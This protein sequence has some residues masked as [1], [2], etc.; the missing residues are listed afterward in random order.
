MLKSRDL[1]NLLNRAAAALE[2]PGD[3]SQEDVEVLI[4]DLLA[5]AEEIERG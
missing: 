5:A 1:K 3:L 2:T 4:A